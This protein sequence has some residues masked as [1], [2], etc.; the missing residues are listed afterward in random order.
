[1]VAKAIQFVTIFVL[2]FVLILGLWGSFGHDVAA[3]I[4]KNK[5]YQFLFW[6]IVSASIA[7]TF[8]FILLG[9]Q[10]GFWYD[11][12]LFSANNHPS[13]YNDDAPV[14]SHGCRC[15]ANMCICGDGSKTVTCPCLGKECVCPT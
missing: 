3:L 8:T 13:E 15:E 9:I 4:L 1:M 6:I 14:F 12:K 2:L 7:T 11:P 5:A 10:E